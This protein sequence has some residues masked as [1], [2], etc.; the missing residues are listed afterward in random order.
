MFGTADTLFGDTIGSSVFG[1]SARG[2]LAGAAD[3]SCRTLDDGTCVARDVDGSD[4]GGPP[5]D[6]TL[7]GTACC[8]GGVG[9]TACVG[10]VAFVGGDDG[11]LNRLVSTPGEA[12]GAALGSIAGGPPGVPSDVFGSAGGVGWPI[13]AWNKLFAMR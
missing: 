5:T 10:G 12:V 13:G 11:T 7:G 1:T 3:G 8:V 4:S 6:G 2:T 9:G